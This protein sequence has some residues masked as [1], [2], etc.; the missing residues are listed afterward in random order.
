M[1]KVE[2][3]EMEIYFKIKVKEFLGH[4]KCYKNKIDCCI[5]Y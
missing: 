2:E 3:E 4:V 5:Y 1:K